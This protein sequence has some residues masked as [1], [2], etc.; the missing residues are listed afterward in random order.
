[1]TRLK[2]AMA[3]LGLLLMLAGCAIGQPREWVDVSTRGANYTEDYIYNVSIRIADGQRTGIGISGVNEFSRGGTSGSQCCASIPGVGQTIKVI[4]HVGGRQEDESQ[5]RTYSRD[6][7]VIGAMPKK[8]DAHNI[9]MVRFF[10]EHQVEAELIP[11]R[12]EPGGS[13]S[14][15]VDKLYFGQRVMRQKGE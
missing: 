8:K 15:R 9:L 4:W 2:Q 1:M 5:W 10:P 11:D 14:P 6:V 7:M 12:G 13:S 3:A